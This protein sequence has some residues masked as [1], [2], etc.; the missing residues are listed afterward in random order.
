MPQVAA[1]VELV[2][3]HLGLLIVADTDFAAELVLV[4]EQIQNHF[5]IAGKQLA[6]QVGKADRLARYNASVVR[7][8]AVV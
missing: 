2:E 1:K 8:E 3:R 5:Q 6:V 7:W 4:V